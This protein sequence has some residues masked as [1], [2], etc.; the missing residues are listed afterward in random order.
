MD[1]GSNRMGGFGGGGG[2]VG[3]I[4]SGRFKRQALLSS[5]RSPN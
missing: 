1:S 4:G 5:G 3:G 2:G